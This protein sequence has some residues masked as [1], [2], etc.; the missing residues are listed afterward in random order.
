MDE[1]QRHNAQ[2]KEENK[3][4]KARL[5]IEDILIDPVKQDSDTITTGTNQQTREG[6]A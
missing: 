2:E 1:G 4:V 5:N 6:D 3:F